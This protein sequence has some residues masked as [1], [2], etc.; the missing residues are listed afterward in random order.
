MLMLSHP[1][2]SNNFAIP[3]EKYII[4]I[5]PSLDVEIMTYKGNGRFKR[6]PFGID[7]GN[8]DYESQYFQIDLHDN[9]N[10]TNTYIVPLEIIL[11]TQSVKDL[12]DKEIYS[13]DVE[14]Y[15]LFMNAI[16]DEFNKSEKGRI[17]PALWYK[18]KISDLIYDEKGLEILLDYQFELSKLEPPLEFETKE[19]Y[20]YKTC[21]KLSPFL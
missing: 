13:K 19:S 14:S 1:N 18:D 16:K 2:T 7:L 8:L 4:Q 17:I 15:S 6:C 3:S 21:K 20:I 11:K 9:T 5:K 12:L 10:N